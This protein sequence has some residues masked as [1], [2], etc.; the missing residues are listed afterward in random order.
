M[1]GRSS[2]I[3]IVRIRRA[4]LRLAPLAARRTP[5]SASCARSRSRPPLALSVF[6][7]RA[8]FCLS[9]PHLSH[10]LTFALCRSCA[11]AAACATAAARG[12]GAAARE[13]I[14]QE[15][16][17]TA[18]GGEARATAGRARARASARGRARRA[19]R[20]ERCKALSDLRS[21]ITDLRS[22]TIA[23]ID[24]RPI[25]RSPGNPNAM[26][27]DLRRSR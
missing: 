7:S 24:D 25:I 26:I 11:E 5:R 12:N 15:A 22:S 18:G 8:S 9:A 23:M 20:G 4:S 1:I 17:A 10:L 19:A 13:Q 21:P 27:N 16:R 2:I 3:A 14:E 6:I